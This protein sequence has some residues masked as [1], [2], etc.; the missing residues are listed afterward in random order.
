MTI[1]GFNSPT[2]QVE[3]KQDYLADHLDE[4]AERIRVLKRS[5]LAD[6][7]RAVAE[8]LRRA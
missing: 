2:D 7:L 8:D 6:E 4:L 1:P 3:R 5:F